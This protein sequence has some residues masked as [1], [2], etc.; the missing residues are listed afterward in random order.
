[1]PPR[2]S[3]RNVHVDTVKGR[4]AAAGVLV[5]GRA[6]CKL[7]RPS[8]AKNGAEGLILMAIAG[9]VAIARAEAGKFQSL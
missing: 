5:Y 6:V 4:R 1:M 9:F 2:K 7:I 3:P 8:V